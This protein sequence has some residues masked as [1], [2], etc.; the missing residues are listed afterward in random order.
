MI[1]FSPVIQAV[2]ALLCYFSYKWSDFPLLLDSNDNRTPSGWPL[3]QLV[4]SLRHQLLDAADLD[5][6]AW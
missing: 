2:T 3:K 1:P 6:Q 4:S 5:H